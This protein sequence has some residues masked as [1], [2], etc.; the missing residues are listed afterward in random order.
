MTIAELQ[1][2]VKDDW[3][4]SS[5]A[6]PSRE[7]QLL[8]IIEEFGEVAEAIRKDAGHKVRKEVA[9]DVGSELADLI[10]AITTL[11]NTYNVDLSGE[12]MKF[13]QRLAERHARGF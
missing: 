3:A 7:L 1:Q 9:T 2:W 6:I 8:Y 10:I 4:R 11:A 13:Q 5:N 12:I